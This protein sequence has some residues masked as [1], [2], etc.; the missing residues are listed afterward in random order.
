MI[1]VLPP[2]STGSCINGGAGQG[3]EGGLRRRRPGFVRV[4][5][6]LA[7]EVVASAAVGEHPGPENLERTCV[8]PR[9]LCRS[10]EV[11]GVTL[12]QPGRWLLPPFYVVILKEN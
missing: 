5:G 11:A 7:P 2:L 8:S 12:A 10:H 1:F 3:R 9:D 6:R 4:R